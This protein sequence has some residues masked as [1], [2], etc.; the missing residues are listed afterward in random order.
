MVHRDETWED[1][2]AGIHALPQINIQITMPIQYEYTLLASSDHNLYVPRYITMP[3]TPQIHAARYNDRGEL[4]SSWRGRT[5]LP[6]V[7]TKQEQ[8]K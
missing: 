3:Y 6:D 7:N 2:R 4:I 8:C 5:S 1:D